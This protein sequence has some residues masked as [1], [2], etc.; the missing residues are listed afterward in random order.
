MDM[1]VHL[2]IDG[3]RDFHR[4]GKYLGCNE[5]AI[6]TI[7]PAAARLREAKKRGDLIVSLEDWHGPTEEEYLRTEEGRN[8]PLPHGIYG[9][10]GA[11]LEP[12]YQKIFADAMIVDGF[13]PEVEAVKWTCFGLE[14]RDFM[15]RYCAIKSILEPEML[16]ITIRQGLRMKKDTFGSENLLL[17]LKALRE[18]GHEIAEIHIEGGV[19]TSICDTANLVIAKTGAPNA[20]IILHGDGCADLDPEKHEAALRGAKLLHAVIV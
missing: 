5:A 3:I 6:R 16:R 17:L 9:T 7:A 11:E 13:A 8:L 4:G 19:L 10:P 14:S 18:L 2:L 20:R 12:E 1:S 15:T